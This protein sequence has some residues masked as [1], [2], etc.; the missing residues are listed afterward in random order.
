MKTPNIH[1]K[2]HEFAHEYP[3]VER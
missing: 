2:R 3:L 1:F